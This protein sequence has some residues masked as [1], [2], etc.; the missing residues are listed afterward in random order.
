M[1]SDGVDAQTDPELFW[2]ERYR[3]GS[4]ETSGKP[5]AM[6]RQVTELLKPGSALELGCGKGDDAVW[7]A[8]QGWSVVAVDISATAL[9]YASANAE[10]AGVADRITFEQHD[11]SQ[12]FPDGEFDLVVASFLQ[13]PVA[14][15]RT[16]VLK[17]AAGAV[18]PGGHLLIIEHGSRSPWSS[19]PPD[20]KFP[21]AEETLASLALG[22]SDWSR[23]RVD[24]VERRA[25][26][27]GGQQA[28]VYDNVIFLRRVQLP[29]T[30]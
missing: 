24:A 5:G 17:Q 4:P 10:R 16:A 21:T 28:D 23:R 15:S 12:T 6:L 2:E 20:T 29:Q 22:E 13:S 9:S 27:P 14:L 8:R 19:S 25:T 7:L 11:V 30:G 1:S 3:S 18:A 26:G